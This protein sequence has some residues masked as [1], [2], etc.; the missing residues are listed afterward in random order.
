MWPQ[1]T[2]EHIQILEQLSGQPAIYIHT[3]HYPSK[4]PQLSR[5][6]APAQFEEYR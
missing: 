6:I 5:K 1:N 4:M 2:S 3:A